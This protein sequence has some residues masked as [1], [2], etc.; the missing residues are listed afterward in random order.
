M[1]YMTLIGG[2]P[3]VRVG[4]PEEDRHG[5]RTYPVLVE[6]HDG[7][8]LAIGYA[9]HHRRWPAPKV[10]CGPLPG[11]E[12]RVALD[13]TV[14]ILVNDANRLV[15]ADQQD[16]ETLNALDAETERLDR[17]EAQIRQQ[18]EVLRQKREAVRQLVEQRWTRL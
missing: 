16:V 5:L 10:D 7:Q 13:R 8:W 17:Q 14:A 11:P 9:Q 18:R 12:V 1:P 15:D 6:R 4:R 3:K 2:A